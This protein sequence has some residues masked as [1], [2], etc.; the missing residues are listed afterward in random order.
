MTFWSRYDPVAVRPKGNTDHWAKM[1]LRAL[2]YSAPAGVRRMDI[3]PTWSMPQQSDQV[4]LRST[5]DYLKFIR[6]DDAW[7]RESA[8]H[9]QVRFRFE[10][11]GTV[12][13]IPKEQ[14]F[15]DILAQHLGGNLPGSYNKRPKSLTYKEKLHTTFN[16]RAKEGFQ[17]WL[18]KRP[19]PTK[20]GRYGIGSYKTVLGIGNAPRT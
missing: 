10:A 12:S 11:D 20:F 17:Y 4:T 6:N 13:Q 5:D 18:I 2:S 19:E 8:G 7:N 15:D 14:R 3:G 9:G 16:Q 1:K